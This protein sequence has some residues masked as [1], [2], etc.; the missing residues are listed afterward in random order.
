MRLHDRTLRR[1]PAS[2]CPACAVSEAC[3]QRAPGSGLIRMCYRRPQPVLVAWSVRIRSPTPSADRVTWQD[4]PLGR[5]AVP[6]NRDP[7]LQ[8]MVKMS[9]TVHRLAR[10]ALGVHLRTTTSR[11]VGVGCGR[12]RGPLKAVTPLVSMQRPMWPNPDRHGGQGSRQPSLAEAPAVVHLAM[13]NCAVARADVISEASLR[14]SRDG[15]GALAQP[16]AFSYCA[17]TSAGMRPRSL[18]F[19]PRALAQSRIAAE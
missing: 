7:C 8:S 19:R 13:G 11:R 3:T 1:L 10:S 15:A 12:Q 18:T 4:N 9:S 16:C 5:L 6:D 17:A 14:E 2:P